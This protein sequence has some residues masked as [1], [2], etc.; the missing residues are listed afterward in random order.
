MYFK[1]TLWQP[2]RIVWVTGDA[3]LPSRKTHIMLSSLNP[4]ARKMGSSSFSHSRRTAAG[5]YMEN[6]S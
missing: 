6:I 5:K 4:A 1:D 3:T 2:Y